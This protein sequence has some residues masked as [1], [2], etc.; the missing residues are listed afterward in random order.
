MKPALPTGSPS[1]PVLVL[2]PHF[3]DEIL[4]CGALLAGIEDKSLIRVVFACDGRGSSDLPR[5]DGARGASDLSVVRAAESKA[6]LGVLGIPETSISQ[7]NF[8]DGSLSSNGEALRAA[9]EKITTELNPLWILAPFRFDRHP[10]HMALARA[11]L[12]L[13]A[14]CQER[15]QLLEYFVYIRWRLFPKR[16]IRT[17]VRADRLVRVQ[18]AGLGFLKRRALDCF[19]TQTTRYFPWQARPVL[20]DA[21]LTE[22]SAAPET[23]LAA[24]AGGCDRD[25][26]R[27]PGGLVRL[28]VAV[29]PFCKRALYAWRLKRRLNRSPMP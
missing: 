2:A 20:T 13:P 24:P 19:V 6:A 10:D 23:F 4:G 28:I 26:L 9:L 29:E 22:V 18:T 27:W 15:A 3:D 12:A 16:D 8:P 17:V 1:G 21:L 14:V 11:A 7:L 5:P 25:V